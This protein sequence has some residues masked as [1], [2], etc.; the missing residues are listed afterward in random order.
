M[1]TVVIAVGDSRHFDGVYSKPKMKEYYRNR[2]NIYN[3]N[4]HIRKARNLL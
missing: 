1:E 4:N 2:P 3:I